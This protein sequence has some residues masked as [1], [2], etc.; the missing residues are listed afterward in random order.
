MDSNNYKASTETHDQP[1]ILSQDQNKGWRQLPDT[2]CLSIVS[3]VV[4][5]HCDT[6]DV[7]VLGSFRCNS[8]A[9]QEL[10]PLRIPK[11]LSSLSFLQMILSPPL[12]GQYNSQYLTP[13]RQWH[14]PMHHPIL[15]CSIQCPCSE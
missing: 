3:T 15:Q 4:T 14:I 11:H 1:K 2:H 5:A 8:H 7:R 12:R 10:H 9:F 6:P 13:Q